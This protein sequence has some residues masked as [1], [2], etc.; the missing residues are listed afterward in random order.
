[1]AGR[2]YGRGADGGH[3]PSGGPVSIGRRVYVNSL[4]YETTWQELK[5]H[6]KQA[7]AVVHADVLTV[8]GATDTR[9]SAAQ[10]PA[11]W[12]LYLTDQCNGAGTEFERVGG[13]RSV[14]RSG[15]QEYMGIYALGGGRLPLHV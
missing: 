9:E 4:A 2:G 6:F 14:T 8:R 5:D 15:W 1:M 11:C 12:C 3:G 13:L 10:G 7:G